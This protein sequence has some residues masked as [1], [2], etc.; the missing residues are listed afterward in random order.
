[1]QLLELMCQA[2]YCHTPWT[3]KT[4]SC[5][6]KVVPHSSYTGGI[7]LFPVMFSRWATAQYHHIQRLY[8]IA[9]HRRSCIAIKWFA[10]GP[11]VVRRKYGPDSGQDSGRPV[12]ME[13]SSPCVKFQPGD[14]RSGPIHG[15][16]NDYTG[17][18]YTVRCGAPSTVTQCDRCTTT[19][20]PGSGGTDMPRSGSHTATPPCHRPVGVFG[21]ISGAWS[22]SHRSYGRSV[23]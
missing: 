8:Y 6:R 7:Q 9:N 14:Y 23:T 3:L 2:L 15:S 22:P 5:L 11:N 1:M 18:R 4:A 20:P 17:H 19:T 16:R 21:Y 13:D 12:E 10:G